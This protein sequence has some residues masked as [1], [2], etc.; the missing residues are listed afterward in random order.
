MKEKLNKLLLNNDFTENDILELVPFLEVIKTFKNGKVLNHTIMAIKKAPFD[1]EI[2]L[3]LLF[4]DVGK[5]FTYIRQNNE[6]KY[7]KHQIVS[8]RYANIELKKLHYD[9]EI[10]KNVCLLIK[11]HMNKKEKTSSNRTI[12]RL[13][14]KMGD[15][16]FYKLLLLF[17][18][19]MEGTLKKVNYKTYQQVLNN[20]NVWENREKTVFKPS[21]YYAVNGNDLLSLGYKGIELGKILKYLQS[22]VNSDINNNNKEFLLSRIPYY[23]EKIGE[24]YENK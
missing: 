10:I 7:P 4:H 9:K 22:L 24:N 6:D 12:T 3:A 19:D 18:A 23:F 15:K 5:P 11:E 20:I 2:R 8:V 21:E 17:K 16:L 13:Y 14:N 1:L